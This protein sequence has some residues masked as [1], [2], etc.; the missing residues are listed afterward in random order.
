MR[1]LISLRINEE[2]YV[3]GRK[4]AALERRSFGNW[5]EGLIAE[6]LAA[7]DA[8]AQTKKSVK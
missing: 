6:N 3:D 7:D 1:R 2:L 5:V 8:Q 4:K